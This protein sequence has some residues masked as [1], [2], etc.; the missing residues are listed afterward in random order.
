MHVIVTVII[1]VG[2]AALLIWAADWTT[3]S[4]RRPTAID[5]LKRRLA[6]GEI[7]R[8]EYEEKRQLIGR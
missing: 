4:A 1:F 3:V 7:G 2:L 8:A 6:R 5:V